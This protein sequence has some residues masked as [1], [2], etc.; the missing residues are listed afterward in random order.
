MIALVLISSSLSAYSAQA[1]LAWDA[2]SGPDVAGYKI[3]YGKVPGVYTNTIDTGIMTSSDVSNL[4]EGETYYFASTAYDSAGN[5]SG[6]SNEVTK[7]VPVSTQYSLMVAQNGTG[8]GTVTGSGITCGS[9]CSN[10]FAPGTV[11]TLSAAPASGSTFAGWSG[12]GCSGIGTCSVTM[13][14]STSVTA[15]FN[16]SV[17]NFDITATAKGS[18]TITA[19]NNPNVS[20][21]TSGDTTISLVKVIK[22]SNQ[23]FSVTPNAGNY[24]V[25]I[26]VD[27]TIVAANL[28]SYNYT[29]SNITAN[30]TI[31]AVFAT[32]TYTITPSAGTGGS[33]SPASARV[34]YGGSQ[35]FTI[36]PNSGY[37]VADVKVNGTSVGAVS[38]YTFSK[39][40]SDQTISATF[41]ATTSSY[42]LT[43][44][45]TS[46]GTISPAGTVTASAGS[47]KTFS[48]TPNA[49][50]YTVSIS[51]DGTIVAANLGSY[52]YTFSNIT[53][54]HTIAAVFATATY[55]ITPSAG[56]GG[57]ISPASA[58]VNYGGS[59]TFTITPNSGYK[60]ADVKVNGTSVGAVSS[61]T[62]SKVTSDQ[63]I[64]ATFTATT[65]SYALT[66]S[67][68]SGGT[69][70]PAGTVTASAG[71]SKTFA[72]KASNNRYRISD[73]KVDGVSKGAISLFTFSN[74]T[75]NHTIQAYFSK[76]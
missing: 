72:I 46:G 49:G 19:V 61:Y 55:T 16:S 36:T 33:I 39:V 74:I 12:G 58:R 28:G 2:V 7:L 56:T 34:N 54:N 43:A 1:T 37:K 63:T 29:F 3:H 75:A 5:Q 65:S 57:S 22:G 6:Y 44:S 66:A 27:G 69:I 59:Q 4:T 11:V 73:V 15:T 62:F 26:S 64:S 14:A 32:A 71:S 47:S 52:N 25:S 21:G 70:S 67:A 35:T 60:V 50:N 42:A 20:Q 48:I 17:A 68:T 31:A 10:V 9:V 30:H 13:N 38:S 24:T 76:N 23:V 41:T 51:V 53:A 40:T 45:A 18:G 8:S